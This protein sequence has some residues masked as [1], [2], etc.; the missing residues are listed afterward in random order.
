MKKWLKRLLPVV[1]AVMLCFGSCL[2]AFAA[3]D[4]EDYT[5]AEY[6][7][8]W[9]GSAEGST[10]WIYANDTGPFYIGT[11]YDKYGVIPA[12]GCWYWN[13]GTFGGN[14]AG[15]GQV[16]FTVDDYNA[17]KIIII[18]SSHDILYDDG[19]VF[20]QKPSPIL[21]PIMA[22]AG[23]EKTLEPILLIL[24]IGLACLVG[25]IA[26]RKALSHLQGV[27]HQA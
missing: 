17:G 26:L 8:R 25:W 9:K 27:L 21:E 11:A 22:E 2:T 23:T 15:A 20:F 19:T 14:N 7:L 3:W 18:D 6:Y 24:P 12:S 4:A 16:M 1:M 10:E 13:N 5:K